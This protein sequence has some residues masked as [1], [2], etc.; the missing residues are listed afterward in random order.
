MNLVKKSKF[1]VKHKRDHR[2]KWFVASFI[3]K[4]LTPKIMYQ[5]RTNIIKYRLV[6]VC[7][8]I[9]FYYRNAVIVYKI[10]V[11]QQQ[12]RTEAQ[13][14]HSNYFNPLQQKENSVS[15]AQK[16][17]SKMLSLFCAKKEWDRKSINTLLEQFPMKQASQITF[18]QHKFTLKCLNYNLISY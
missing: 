17:S 5:Y 6:G 14:T 3:R 7:D 8:V 18:S 16:I 1:E 12:T 10:M 4:I 15:I 13:N 11:V 9:I 2:S